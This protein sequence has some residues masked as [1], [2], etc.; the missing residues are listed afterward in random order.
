M[1]NRKRK[2]IDACEQNNKHVAKRMFVEA[3]DEIKEELSDVDF[4]EM[5]VEC[6]KHNNVAL[7]DTLLEVSNLDEEHIVE[8]FRAAGRRSNFESMKTFFEY[9]EVSLFQPHLRFCYRHA[10][11]N[12]RLDI[13][14]WIASLGSLEINPTHIIRDIINKHGY[15][16]V[17]PGNEYENINRAIIHLYNMGGRVFTH[18]HKFLNERVAAT[19]YSRNIA[20]YTSEAMLNACGHHLQLT[21]SPNYVLFMVRELKSRGILSNELVDTAHPRLHYF[22]V[23]NG[24]KGSEKMHDTYVQFKTVVL[25]I[26]NQR[27]ISVLATLITSFIID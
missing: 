4:P 12:G 11:I 6:A 20:S 8:A 3:S 17:K 27:T 19:M 13:V 15:E 16:L 24:Y 2:I 1:D 14:R 7:L 21:Y 10:C 18:Y 26:L 25:Q 22:L 23:S 5:M 9:Y